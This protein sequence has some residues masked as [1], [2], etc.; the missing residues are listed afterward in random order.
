MDTLFQNVRYAFRQIR[1]SA[2]FSLVAATTIALGIGVTTVIFTLV[3]AVVLRPLPVEDPAGLVEVMQVQ[4]DGGVNAAIS[5]PY[6]QDYREGGERAIQLGAFGFSSVA[7]QGGDWAESINGTFVTGDYFQ[8]LGLVPTLGRFF[9]PDEERP[10]V[11][12]PVVVISHGLWEREMGGDPDVVGRTVRL[13]SQPLTVIGVAPEGYGGIV[14]GLRTDVWVPIPMYAE[15]NPGSNI[16][17]PGQSSWLVMFGRL[18]PGFEPGEAEAVLSGVTRTIS[19][20]SEWD[21]NLA[22]VRITRYGGIP[23]PESTAIHFFLALLMGTATLVLL[24]A[25]VNVAGMLLA[26]ATTRRREVGIRLALGA[27]RRRLIG[28]LLTE[29]TLLFLLGGT[30]GLLLAIWLSDLVTAFP[31]ALPVDLSL[32]ASPDVRV[33]TFAFLLSLATGLAVG[34]LPALRATRS[35]LMSALKDGGGATMDRSRLRSAFVVGQISLSLLLLVTAGLLGRSLQNSLAIDPGMNADG[36]VVASL[37]LAPHGYDAEL[38]LAFYE[39]YMERLRHLPGVQ[40]VTAAGMVPLGL[41]Q[42]VTNV[43]VP[44]HEPPGDASAFSM[45]FNLVAPEYFATLEIPLE[46][47]EFSRQDA[48][49][50]PGVVIVNRAMADRFWP[51]ESALGELVTIWGQERRIVGVTVQ[52]RYGSYHEDPIPYVYL[53]FGQEYSAG[54]TIHVRSS[55]P[56]GAVVAMMRSELQSLDANLPLVG[57]GALSD[58][59][60]LI[61]LP[62]RIGAT[63]I[64][65]FGLLGLLLAA[66]GLYGVL[67]YAVSQRTREL[68]VRAA[69]GARS[70]DI[71]A[72]VLRQGVL[73]L[74]VGLAVGFTLS[75]AVTRLLG[76]LL[77]GVTPTDPVTFLSVSLLLAVVALGA[78]Y[79]PARRAMKVDPIIALKAD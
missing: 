50:S 60:Q 28:Q 40:S 6:F 43:Q 46:G 61:L 4:N 24:I 7:F 3:N 14:T 8:L 73:L 23:G 27:G 37:N 10:E 66:V 54:M 67:A 38:G 57:P 36:V 41:D 58:R 76:G 51:G 18:A 12:V 63:L 11:P 17:A 25:C 2:T 64:G 78:S 52:G 15:L 70:G 72:L 16:Y 44:G 55:E 29:S 42:N 33:L 26:R 1:R 59:I 53:P 34:L 9:A 56:V 13:N 32:D 68:G 22:G 62:Q 45:D 19:E 48:P 77:A 75:L 20:Q 21:Q 65:I 49:D 74:A 69:L 79:I 71:L 47:R 39:E 30:G 31:V 5:Y 35:G